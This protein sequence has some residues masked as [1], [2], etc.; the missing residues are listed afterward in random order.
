M[1]NVRSGYDSIAD[2]IPHR[3]D[4]VDASRAVADRTEHPELRDLTASIAAV[5][6]TKIATMES[7]LAQWYAVAARDHMRH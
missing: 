4:A 3:H 1:H 7:W 5:Q 6:A 2:M